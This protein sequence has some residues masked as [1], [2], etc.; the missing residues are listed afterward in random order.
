MIIVYVLIFIALFLMWGGLMNHSDSKKKKKGIEKEIKDAERKVKVER[1]RFSSLTS[2]EKDKEYNANLRKTL[3]KC[4]YLKIKDLNEIIESIEEKP[5]NHRLSPFADEKRG[6][7]FVKDTIESTK[8]GKELYARIYP[9]LDKDERCDNSLSHEKLNKITKYIEDGVNSL[10]SNEFIEVIENR[11]DVLNDSI[12]DINILR[13]GFLKYSD[14]PKGEKQENAFNTLTVNFNSTVSQTVKTK[15]LKKLSKYFKEKA[16]DYDVGIIYYDFLLNLKGNGDQERLNTFKSDLLKNNASNRRFYFAKIKSNI[17]DKSYLQIGTTLEE[18]LSL[19][20]NDV[21][22]IVD[23]YKDIELE[24]NMAL[25]LQY[26]LLR[27][28][29]PHSYIAEDEFSEFERFDGYTEIVPMK[30]KTEV[31]KDIDNVVENYKEVGFV[32][33]N[34]VLLN[35]LN[36]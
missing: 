11:K 27:K 16:V 3:D 12:K 17:D 29:R 4:F 32:F 9:L 14:K 34:L 36:N 15:L 7:K 35:N 18:G 19:L 28:Y 31:C 25:A 1:E 23:V 21:V 10:I 2:Q 22:D 6:M 13:E 30:C 24:S 33:K 20:S 5:L 26:Q 8:E